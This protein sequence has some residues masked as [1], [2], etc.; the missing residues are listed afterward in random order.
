MKMP[1]RHLALPLIA[2]LLGACSH[3]QFRKDETRDQIDAELRQAR[4]QMV[5]DAAAEKALLPPLAVISPVPEVKEPRFDLSV[6]NSP[7]P[8]VFMAIVSGTRYNMLITPEVAGNI[9]INLKDVTVREALDSIRELYGYEY[10]IQGNRI[11]IQPNTCRHGYSISITWPPCAPAK[12]S[13]A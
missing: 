11:S 2:V 6:V 8:Q 9:T 7:A 5:A 12:P 13:C 10:R 1:M 3:S 4:N